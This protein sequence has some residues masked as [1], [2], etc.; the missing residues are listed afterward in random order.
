MIFF[1]W[2]LPAFTFVIVTSSFY[3]DVVFYK[4]AITEGI[5]PNLWNAIGSFGLF[6]FGLAILL[7]ES[8]LL[9]TIAVQILSNTYSIGCLTFG[10]LCG[11]FYALANNT[12]L[13]WWQMGLFGVTSVFLLLIVLCYNTFVWYLTFLLQNDRGDKSSFIIKLEQMSVIWRFLLGGLATV[14]I[15]L[16][17]FN[18]K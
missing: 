18:V 13:E 7:S 4:K 5:G 10:L 9:R 16:L 3:P 6:A 17:F 15:T 11:Q 1:C 2:A 12:S 8:L 14:P